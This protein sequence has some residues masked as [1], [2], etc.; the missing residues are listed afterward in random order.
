M[1]DRER[2]RDLSARLLLLHKILLDRER[3][4]Y[5]DRRGPIPSGELLFLVLNDEEFAWLRVLSGMIAEIDSLADTD[6]PL[7]P[8]SVQRVFR[9]AYRLLK[10]GSGGDFQE[11]Y[12]AALQESPDVV[13]AHADVSRAL[14]ASTPPSG[15]AG[16]RD[17]DGVVRSPAEAPVNLEDTLAFLE[18]DSKLLAE[19]I[20]ALL[21]ELP[22]YI[23][24]LREATR[25]AD[26]VALGRIAHLI[27]GALA[28]IHA[29]RA[30]ALTARLEDLA[31]EGQSGAAEIAIALVV[32]LDRLGVFLRETAGKRA[33]S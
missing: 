31:R 27:K 20:Q 6:D 32:E 1:D 14:R 26:A 3:C 13:M 29:E 8:E 33:S 25:G 22:R 2:L 10:T 12:H 17:R 11:K 18:G 7:G 9:E 30:R 24:D 5:E 28:T 4:A 19:L 16:R 23:A 21:D 15:L